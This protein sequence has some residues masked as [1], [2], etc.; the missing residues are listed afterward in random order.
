[1]MKGYGID[2]LK[3]YYLIL[4]LQVNTEIKNWGEQLQKPFHL[5]WLESL[6]ENFL[7]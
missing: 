1:M 5:R 3:E 4:L 6:L 2:F 7:I